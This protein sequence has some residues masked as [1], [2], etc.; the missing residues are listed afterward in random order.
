M[1]IKNGGKEYLLMG[2]GFGLGMGIYFFFSTE[3]ILIALIS[4]VVSGVMFGG[5]MAL[6]SKNPEKRFKQI[7]EEVSSQ[8]K[9]ICEGVVTF[10]FSNGWLFLL[11]DSLLL[12]SKKSKQGMQKTLIKLDSITNFANEGKAIVIHANGTAHRLTVAKPHEWSKLIEEQW[13]KNNQKLKAENK[14]IT[15]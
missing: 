6:A 2:L 5:L 9:I 4:G 11:E 10:S 15:E 1:I 3:M 12:Y 14:D 7:R 8:N 13:N